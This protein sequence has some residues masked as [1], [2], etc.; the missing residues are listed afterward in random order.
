MERRAGRNAVSSGGRAA[1][2]SLCVC[3]WAG[4]LPAQSLGQTPSPSP[5]PTNDE[6]QESQREEVESERTAYS[7]TYREP[8][9]TFTTEVSTEQ[10]HFKDDEGNWRE[11]D[12][13]LVPCASDCAY[14]TR[15]GPLHME[16]AATGSSERLATLV[17]R[18]ARGLAF[19]LRGG[20]PT[21]PVAD[22]NRITY[23]EVLPG[24]DLVFEA[25]A[26]ALKELLVLHRPPPSPQ[27]GPLRYRF[28]LRATGLTARETQRGEIEL[29]DADGGVAFTLPRIFMYDSSGDERS[30]EPA[31]TENSAIGIEDRNGTQFIVVTP[32]SQW[33]NDPDRV[34]PVYIDPSV[35]KTPTTDT[36]IQSNIDN[37]RQDGSDELKAGTYDGGSTKARSLIRFNI[38]EFKGTIINDAQLSVR[39]FHSWS[40]NSRKL[41]VRRVTKDW[42]P[43]VTWPNRPTLQTEPVAQKWFAYGYAN[44]SDCS[45]RRVEFTLTDTVQKWADLQWDNYGVALRAADET[46]NYGWK[47][48]R[49]ADSNHPP[50]LIVN[51]NTPPKVP[52]NLD[53]VD[54]TSNPDDTPTLKGIYNDADSGDGGYLEF[55]V[56]PVG[57]PDNVIAAGNGTFADPGGVSSWTVPS[58][59]LKEGIE[60]RWRARAYDHK[61]WSAWTDPRISYIVAK[62]PP[63]KPGISSTTHP[64]Q[65][66]WVANDDPTF[67]WTEPSDPSG[68]QG[69]SYEI[70]QNDNPEYDA[71]EFADPI[72][73]GR[74]A[75]YSD[76]RDGVWYFHVRAQDG[77][78]QWGDTA[79]YQVNIDDTAPAI[80]SVSSSSHPDPTKWYAK[81]TVDFQ[82]SATDVSGITG[83]SYAWDG[84]ADESEDTDATSI[85]FSE[86]SD[87]EHRFEVRAK[88][89]SGLWGPPRDVI[90]RVDTSPPSRPEVSSSTHPVEGTYYNRD[91]VE[92][93]WSSSDEHSGV[94]GY[95]FLLDQNA[96]TDPSSAPLS[97]DTQARYENLSEGTHYFHVKAKNGSGLWSLIRHFEIRV[98]A[99]G[100]E[101]VI[102]DSSHPKG[103]NGEVLWYSNEN[104]S[105]AW[106]A[107]DESGIKGYSWARDQLSNTTPDDDLD[108]D[109]AKTST[110]YTNIADGI[111]FFHI[112][113]Q[114]NAGAFGLPTHFEFRIDTTEPLPPKLVTSTSHTK[115]VAFDNRQ[116]TMTWSPGTDQPA[117]SGVAGYT[118]SFCPCPN[119]A[120]D[121]NLDAEIDTRAEEDLVA[122]SG[123]EL[124]DD[125]YFFHISTVDGA[126]NTSDPVTYG[127]MV[128]RGDGLPVALSPTLDDILVA[129]SDE[130][131]LEQFYPYRATALGGDATAYSNLA[132]G[133]LV[134]QKE[135]VRVPGIGLNT[136]I[137]HT[138]NSRRADPLLRQSGTGRGWTLSLTDLDAGLEGAE[139]AVNS[140][141]LNSP[142]LPSEFVNNSLTV[143]GFLIEFTDGDGTTH[144]FVRDCDPS[145][146]SCGANGRWAS[147]PGV[148]L[149]VRAIPDGAGGVSSYELIRPDGVTYTARPIEVQPAEQLGATPGFGSIKAWRISKTSDRN[150]NELLFEHRAFGPN[151]LDIRAVSVR[152][153]RYDSPNATL[154]YDDRGNLTKITA[155]PQLAA[156]EQV[157]PATGESR[158]WTRDITFTVNEAGSLTAIE[159]N[160]DLAPDD[161]SRRKM[162]FSYR[163]V[164]AAPGVFDERE[165]V[166]VTD[167]RAED[168]AGRHRTDF[169]Y[170]TG[171]DLQVKTI[172]DRLGNPWTF[173]YNLINANTGETETTV[174]A[175]VS[176]SNTSTT[177]YRMSGRGPISDSDQR[178]A[179]HNITQITDE[180]NNA[181]RV[182]NSYVWR[183]NRLT[184]K[185]DGAN[186]TTN[187]AYN[188]L[189]MLTEVSEPPP[190]DPNRPADEL[191]P[192]APQAR[193]RT[194]LKYDFAP[195]GDIDNCSPPSSDP[196][197]DDSISIAGYCSSIAEMER[198]TY[199][200]DH[201]TQTRVTDFDYDLDGNLTLVTARNNANIEDKP[202]RTLQFFYYD[203][204]A[205]KKID[206]PRQITPNDV[207][208]FGNNDGSDPTYG[209]YSRSGQPERIEDAADKVKQ[210]RYTPYGMVAKIVD[211][212]GNVT[213]SRYDDRDNPVDIT[214]GSGDKTTFTYDNN[215]NRTS[216]T[217]PRG[218][219]AGGAGFTTTFVYNSNDWLT[220]SN[221]P[222]TTGA[223]RVVTSIDYFRDGTKRTEES[224]IGA[225]TTYAYYANRQLR[226]VTTPA[227]R[228]ETATTTYHYDLAGRLKR[229]VM[230]QTTAGGTRPEQVATY[231]PQGQIEILKETSSSGALDRVLTY[232]YNAHGQQLEV[233][234]PRTNG[235]RVTQ[236]ERRSYNSFGE[237]RSMRRRISGTKWLENTHDY[238]RAGNRISGTQPT[239][240]NDETLATTYRF[241]ELHRV[242]F[243][244]DP[245][246]PGHTATFTY[247]PEGQQK[248]RVDRVDGV[249][250]RT[251][252]LAYNAD[253]TLRSKIT[254]RANGDTLAECNFFAGQPSSGYDANDNLLVSRTLSGTQGCKGGDLIA[255]RQFS[256]DNRNRVIEMVQSVDVPGD[257]AGAVTRT[258]TFEYR[259]DDALTSSVW[260]DGEPG[261]P[262]PAHE[263]SYEHSQGGFL[264][265]VTDWRAAASSTSTFDYLPSGAL[266]SVNLGSGVATAAL[267][268]HE[269]GSVSR[270]LWNATGHAAPVRSHTD[271]TYNVGGLRTAE[272]VSVI[273][274]GTA[275]G[276]DTEGQAAFGYDL[277]DRLTRWTSPFRLSD[278][279]S[280]D[281]P[282]TTYTLDRGGNIIDEIVVADNG[283]GAKK[284]EI[285]STYENG[286]LESRTI[287]T[288]ELVEDV[289]STTTQSFIYTGLGEEKERTST[290]TISS[291]TIND[292]MAS[293]YDPAGHTDEVSNSKTVDGTAA[294]ADPDVDYLYDAS[295]Q[296]IARTEKSTTETET[297][298]YF[299]W[300]MTAALAE[301]TT[302]AGNTEARY[303]VSSQGQVLAEQTYEDGLTGGEPDPTT[304]TFTF[305]LR[306]PDDNVATELE[307][308]GT[309]A[310]QRAYDPYGAAQEGGSSKEE[311][312]EESTLGFQSA[313]TDDVTGNILLGPRIYDPTTPRFTTPDFFVASGPDISLGTDPLTGNRYLFAAANPVGFYEDGYRAY[314]EY[315]GSSYCTGRQA[316]TKTRRQRPVAETNYQVADRRTSYRY[317]VIS[318]IPAQILRAEGLTED[319]LRQLARTGAG[320][321]A[322]TAGGAIAG[323]VWQPG[324]RSIPAGWF[325][326]GGRYV[327]R[328]PRAVGGAASGAGQIVYDALGEERPLGERIGRA[329]LSGASGG[330]GAG[331]GL[332]VGS[333]CTGASLGF[334]APVC[335]GAGVAVG[336]ATTW[337]TR[338]LIFSPLSRLFGW[339]DLDD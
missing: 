76:R 237:L 260:K 80:E 189:G 134:V 325:R 245:Q 299:Y 309:I 99:Q 258:Q 159:E 26:T 170:G 126:G 84:T 119:A 66:V 112:K 129:Q 169:A 315:Y 71:D 227:G 269:D 54:A 21:P 131:G 120:D 292:V 207:T 180:G 262:G 290:T 139:N 59:K 48:F 177:T 32:D 101:V 288:F 298:L 184:K 8:D 171:N 296:V 233:T 188:D 198:T 278:A 18:A 312:N 150:G 56:N 310:A 284:R 333:G 241:D 257:V 161:P 271:I 122:R 34:Y 231:T 50:Q 14:R 78:G 108:G 155:L 302:A 107:S 181:G 174:T 201:A 158:D 281:Q 69:Y 133:N 204:G 73:N 235:D 256:Y 13:T 167:P 247:L 36:F 232:A 303:L 265:K 163:T 219:E 11:I 331:A 81:S 118:W 135:D 127:P 244:D 317:Y 104:P 62:A 153:N 222:G 152:H 100:P 92:L 187:L 286:R 67:S 117:L 280:S 236:A 113:A 337:V 186:N 295:D 121:T 29:V 125:E 172:T 132:T 27:G 138:Y 195:E 60:Y 25:R 214:D 283:S 136:V 266:E 314:C 339:G 28:P 220:E 327:S 49:S 267:G 74:T 47:K 57:E 217:A 53:P 293:T 168:E 22:D 10:I 272:S 96:T 16:F 196:N 316:S 64:N 294:D 123:E 154:S 86:R 215:D 291:T 39:N 336:A 321:V 6:E 246:N 240:S 51:Y 213:T 242:V 234:G 97:S 229:K 110:S 200:P 205:L 324:T 124:P 157:D 329:V 42:D 249:A 37:T 98:D 109:A 268:Y 45:T 285:N 202:D 275:V 141:D 248:T 82:W 55:E 144:R 216:E 307:A 176:D 230:P 252:T 208:T 313:H 332:A 93:S 3:L 102:T 90:V 77:T 1:I 225:I 143:A 94:V 35:T 115:Y 197:P 199:A 52:T 318:D 261:G 38:H 330:L 116:I 106:T 105:F 111:H 114:N 160:S 103:P 297:T 193:I 226:E 253:Y 223:E 264:E 183:Q 173:D 300:G 156:S 323:T 79:H 137:R 311:G 279:S 211:R 282:R 320:I 276:E 287:K 20:A 206:G 12:T 17:D 228:G 7:K 326:E 89:G 322:K 305:L 210:I 182:T 85:S 301:E 338:E 147:P 70:N 44:T 194:V 15:S 43:W 128:I 178:R 63:G 179:G 151:V 165:L 273:H 19:G 191:P 255:R 212:A 146:A 40:C 175:P 306:D 33:L 162:T 142:I 203:S 46:D 31:F 218:N 185:T 23:P 91:D 289:D 149:R 192:G 277:A 274:P 251:T 335:A 304:Q 61:H 5:S 164:E 41:E 250:R 24:V 148:A 319:Q 238:D 9:D 4:L 72:P 221:Q 254:E 308:D 68:I 334:A 88:N 95:K 65:D 263:T 166:T 224:P 58:G 328:F 2:V 87:G 190:N 140:L 209:G 30:Q 270:L 75:S 239:G 83:Y 145:A 243:Q 259:K 130:L